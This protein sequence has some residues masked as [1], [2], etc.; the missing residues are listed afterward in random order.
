[1]KGESG[2]TRSII[3]EHYSWDIHGDEKEV[4]GLL[5]E[6]SKMISILQISKEIKRKVKV[7]LIEVSLTNFILWISKEIK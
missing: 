5:L 3:D 4:K 1:M 6:V 2:V 7:V